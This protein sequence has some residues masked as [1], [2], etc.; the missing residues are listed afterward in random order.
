[1]SNQ[2]DAIKAAIREETKAKEAA[3]SKETKTT[4]KK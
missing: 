3:K 2:R 4:T 1:M